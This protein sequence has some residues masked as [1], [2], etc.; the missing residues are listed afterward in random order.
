MSHRETDDDYDR[1]IIRFGEW[2]VIED[3]DAIQWIVQRREAKGR[4]RWLS[5]KYCTS[6]DGLIRRCGPGLGNVDAGNHG[7][8]GFPGWEALRGL[9]DRFRAG[10]AL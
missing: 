5:E 10:S 2:R 9:P 1:V 8:S 6:R 7:Q 3:A 4:R